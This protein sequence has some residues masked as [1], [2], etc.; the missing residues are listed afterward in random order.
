MHMPNFKISGRNTIQATGCQNMAI[1]GEILQWLVA[2]FR[3]RGIQVHDE[4][5]A[6]FVGDVVMTNIF[7]GGCRVRAAPCT[8]RR[9]SSG[10]WVV[11]V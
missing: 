5:T 7:Y 1:I 2:T 10:F 6:G 9:T 4:A 3:D 11:C 8:N